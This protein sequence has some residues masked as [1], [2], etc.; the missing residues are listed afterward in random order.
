MAPKICPYWVGY[1]LVNPFRRLFQ[2]PEKILEPYVESG[3]MAMDIGCAMGFFSLPMARM[4]GE[5]GKVVCVDVQEK[6]LQSL[7]K[8]AEKAGLADRI[9]IHPSLQDSLS[10]NA[11]ERKIDFA[12]AFAVVHEVPDIFHFFQDVS[13]AMKPGSKC[14]LA[15][16][17]GHVSVED[18]TKTLTLANENGLHFVGQPRIAWSRT[19][20]LMKTQ[21]PA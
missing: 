4:A 12:L 2:N 14:L 16:P 10:L 19:A 20:L 7:R 3:M 5:R 18:F 13:S 6:M 1:L 8:R 11:F 21:G 17:K 15:E 9:I